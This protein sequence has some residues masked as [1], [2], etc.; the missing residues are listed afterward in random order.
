VNRVLRIA[1]YRRLLAAY[2][3]NELA[4][5]V[6]SLTLALLVYRRTGSA[7][8]AT[9]FFLFSQFVPA[10]IS[11]AAVA[12]LDGRRPR[13]VLPALYWFEALVFFALAWVAMHFS[14][15]AV[16]ALALVDGI[17]ALTSRSLARAATVSVTSEAGLLREGNAVANGAFSI[18]FML[19]PVV[20][21]AVVAVGG[22][23]LALIADGCL[24]G[25]IGFTLVTARGLP[26]P[27]TS[28]A[29]A[30][31]RVRAALA[32]ARNH[33]LISRLLLLQAFGVLFF[34]I[35]VPVEVVFAQ[36]TLHAGAAGYGGL[37]SAWGGGAV[38]GAAVYARWRGL[39]NRELI[40][41]GA[42]ALGVGF[43]V[44][45]ASPTISVALVG[46]AVAGVGNG[47]EAVAARTALQELV[48]DRWMALM[49]SLNDSMFQCVPGAGILLGGA[50]TA[51]GS[52]RTAL[53]VAAGGSLLVTGAAWFALSSMAATSVLSDHV[54]SGESGPD[55]GLGIDDPYAERESGES[56]DPLHEAAPAPVGRHQ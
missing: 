43:L 23:S 13:V 41:A 5:M 47:I 11:P 50:L 24:F 46:A 51:L 6:G 48:E 19:G 54:G 29:S 14:L 39:P 49:M 31:G 33:V 55:P 16:L 7:F 34:T 20:G 1:A 42:A 25:L 36:Q 17:A 45:A 35:S 15:V 8:G 38:A 44:M 18:C 52:P 30:K 9:A 3:L 22:T 27:A 32:Y 12:R 28:R 53:A 56:D 21:G 2:T 37:L 4:F 26:E 40:V 10:L